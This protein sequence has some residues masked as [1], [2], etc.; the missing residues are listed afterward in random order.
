MNPKG[1]GKAWIIVATRPVCE[2]MNGFRFLF[3]LKP[4]GVLWGWGVA[5]AGVG[6]SAHMAGIGVGT[7]GVM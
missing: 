7:A 1:A 5:G 2:V 3:F 4:E 6:V